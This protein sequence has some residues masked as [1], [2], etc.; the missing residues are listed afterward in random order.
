MQRRFSL[1]LSSFSSEA[2]D[3]E[4]ME[5]DVGGADPRLDY[6][7]QIQQMKE[8]DHTTLCVR[9]AAHARALVLA[10]RRAARALTAPPYLPFASQVCGVGS[11]RDG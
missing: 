10:A 2:L 4:M 7:M 9:R 8:D 11:P 3:G 1:F 5:E 6:L